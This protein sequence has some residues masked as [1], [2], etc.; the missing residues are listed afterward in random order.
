VNLNLGA[1]VKSITLNPRKNSTGN[2]SEGELGLANLNPETINLFAD[3][4]KKSVGV[5]RITKGSETGEIVINFDRKQKHLSSEKS[6]GELES[7]SAILIKKQ[8]ETIKKATK[9]AKKSNFSSKKKTD[10][11][12]VDLNLSPQKASKNNIKIESISKYFIHLINK[13]KLLRYIYFELL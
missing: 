3:S 6:E 13:F 12:I 4:K 2:Q 8:E 11:A 10:K 7:P 5:N 1:A 9:P